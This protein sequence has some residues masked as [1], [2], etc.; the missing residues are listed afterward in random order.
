VLVRDACE[1][2]KSLADY[3]YPSEVLH[4]RD[5][6]P[7]IKMSDQL[8]TSDFELELEQ[9]DYN[10]CPDTGLW[11]LQNQGFID[12]LESDNSASFHLCG[13]LFFTSYRDC[14]MRIPA[15]LNSFCRLQCRNLSILI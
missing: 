10:R 13:K 9:L 4:N 7:Q 12:F 6:T 14:L 5:W 2:I 8:E 15:N 3:N 11:L 1:L